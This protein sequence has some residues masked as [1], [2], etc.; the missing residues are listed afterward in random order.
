MA[1]LKSLIDPKFNQD[2][3]SILL[4]KRGAV[5][6]GGVSAQGIVGAELDLKTSSS[7]VLWNQYIAFYKFLAVATRRRRSPGLSGT[8]R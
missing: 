6:C 3:V 8:T 1:N 4:V 7:H 5:S 2:D